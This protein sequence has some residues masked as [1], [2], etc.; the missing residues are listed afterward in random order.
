MF[1]ILNGAKDLCVS[2]EWKTAT[3]LH[4]VCIR[5]PAYAQTSKLQ[6]PLQDLNLLRRSF[7]ACGFS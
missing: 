3:R 7:V 1:V 2:L 6:S 5:V 4:R